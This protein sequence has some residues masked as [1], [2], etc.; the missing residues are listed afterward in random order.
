MNRE[1]ARIKREKEERKQAEEEKKEIARRRKLTDAEIRAEDAEKLKPREKKQWNFL[2][3]YYHKGAFFRTFDEKDEIADD[4]K[5]DFG[6]AT[7]EDK[8]DKS[9]L[10]S[11]MQV[12]ISFQTKFI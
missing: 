9:I 7:L 1:L 2:Q 5:W 8:F 11:V 4:K 12:I 6:Q 10:P 3:K